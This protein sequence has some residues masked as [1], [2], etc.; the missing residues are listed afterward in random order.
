[1][2]I[3]KLQLLT[4]F[5]DIEPFTIKFR[6]GLNVIVGENGSGKSTLFYLMTSDDKISDDKLLKKIRTMDYVK[7]SNF[8]FFDT[9]KENPRMKDMNQAKNFEYALVS[10]FR[11]HGESMLPILRAARIFEKVAIMVDEPESGLS[12]KNQMLVMTYFQDA[13]KKG[14]QVIISTHSYLII[15]SV[16]Q[17]FNMD[18]KTW[19]TSAKYLAK[20]TG[21]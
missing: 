1:M 21:E 10:R 8:H 11:S 7:G 12:L 16:P 6:E 13:I 9:E 18:T 14:C 17:V 15:K 5:R 19:V 4:K 20:V 3:K 2:L